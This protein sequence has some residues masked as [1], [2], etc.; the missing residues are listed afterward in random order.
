MYKGGF[1]WEN[2]QTLVWNRSSRILNFTARFFLLE[3]INHSK[4]FSF[5]YLLFDHSGGRIIWKVSG[6]IQNTLNDKR[7]Q[8]LSG[9]TSTTTSD[10]LIKSH[11]YLIRLSFSIVHYCSPCLGRPL[12]FFLSRHCV[13]CH[14]A[15]LTFYCTWPLLSSIRKPRLEPV[16]CKKCQKKSQPRNWFGE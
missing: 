9:L 16:C 7:L 1:S 15:Y 12:D 11:L 6:K 5:V 13:S 4:K 3:Y 14:F 2:P 8:T 10:L